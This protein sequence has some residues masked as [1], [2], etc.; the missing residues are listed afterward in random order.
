MCP[1]TNGLRLKNLENVTGKN[2]THGLICQEYWSS[3][4][5]HKFGSRIGWFSKA[6]NKTL[7]SEV[8]LI[9]SNHLNNKFA[10]NN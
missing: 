7:K 9:R 4:V 2:L 3:I 5:K 10:F 6:L 1:Q 8:P